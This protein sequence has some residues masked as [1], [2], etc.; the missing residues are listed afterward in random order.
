MADEEFTHT[1]RRAGLS[2]ESAARFLGVSAE[3]IRRWRNG[4]ASPPDHRMDLLE[5]LYDFQIKLAA[6]LTDQWEALREK[7]T[8]VLAV[9]ATDEHARHIGW[10]DKAS[11]A[12]VAAIAATLD[13]MISIVI[14]ED[15]GLEDDGDLFDGLE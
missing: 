8:L 3:E 13:P 14:V 1:L 15:L 12:H 6:R 10:P 11:Q 7:K 4:A 5:Q 2:D 9:S